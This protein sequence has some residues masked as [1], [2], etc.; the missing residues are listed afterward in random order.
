MALVRDRDAGDL[1][2]MR[3]EEVLAVGIVEIARDDAAARDHDIL[4]RIGVEEDRVINL[5]AE[6]D[7]VI[8]LHQ[9]IALALGPSLDSWAQVLRLDLALR[10]GRRLL[11]LLL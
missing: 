1:V 4:L 11:L 7:G 6:A 10:G 3:R 8:Q 9:G 2:I 5:S